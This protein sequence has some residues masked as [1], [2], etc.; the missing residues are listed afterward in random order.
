SA[1]GMPRIFAATV[2][3]RGGAPSQINAVSSEREELRRTSLRDWFGTA[4][5]R[6]LMT[7]GHWPRC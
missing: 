1:E 5:K 7:H 6:G 2:G 3:D 4:I